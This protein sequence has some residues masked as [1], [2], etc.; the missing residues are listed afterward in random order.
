[1]LGKG[2]IEVILYVEDMARQVRFYQ[3]ILG[4]KV[5]YPPDLDDYGQEEWVTL[6]T[7]PC[8]LALHGGGRKRLGEDSPMIVF[9]VTNIEAARNNLLAKDVS[10]G[11]IFSA[12]PGVKVCHGRDPEGNPLALESRE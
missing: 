3:D 11:E 2:L 10:L 5:T 7:G 6:D 9:G 12:A 4:F 8:T 1:M